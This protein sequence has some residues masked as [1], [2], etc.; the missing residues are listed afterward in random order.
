MAVRAVSPFF[1]EIQDVVPA[2]RGFFGSGICHLWAVYDYLALLLSQFPCKGGSGTIFGKGI[3]T[4]LHDP[5]TG[6][7]PGHAGDAF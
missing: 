6:A 3:F 4:L 2:D 7:F 1:R 5:F